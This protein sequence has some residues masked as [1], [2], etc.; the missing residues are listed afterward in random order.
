MNRAD[1]KMKKLFFAALILLTPMVAAADD[2]ADAEAKL[3]EY[4]DAFNARDTRTIS[5]A[6]YSAPVH[7]ANQSGHRAYLTPEDAR[8][9]LRN[10]YAQIEDQGWVKS[11]IQRVNACVI[12]EGLVFAEVIYARNTAEGE[13]IPP[14]IRTN[15]YVVQELPVGWRIVAFY[16][17]NAGV[18]LTCDPQ[19]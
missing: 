9:S 13:A 17:K 2:A 11:V 6:I 14:G 3:R 19:E 1:H 8:T 15:I 7:I 4:F 5:E 12:A 10:L 18:K 16:G